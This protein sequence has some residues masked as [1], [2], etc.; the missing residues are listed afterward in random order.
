MDLDPSSKT[1]AM[2]IRGHVGG[3]QD[4][5]KAQRTRK[6]MGECIGIRKDA[7]NAQTAS[8]DMQKPKIP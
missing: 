8:D 3:F 2:D 5:Q 7:P 4:I 6:R 1:K